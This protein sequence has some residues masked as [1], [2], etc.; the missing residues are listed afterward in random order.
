M[1]A[2]SNFE[3]SHPASECDKCT[4]VNGPDCHMLPKTPFKVHMTGTL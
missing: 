3:V 2:M 1:K 4:H